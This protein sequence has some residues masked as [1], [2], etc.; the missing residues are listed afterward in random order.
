LLQNTSILGNLDTIRSTRPMRQTA[1]LPFRV[2]FAPNLAPTSM[3]S[4]LRSIALLLLLGLLSIPAQAHRT[5]ESYI[6]LSISDTEVSGRFEVT[7]KD[8]N[9]V[10]KLDAD[11]DG[12]LTDAEFDAVADQAG[13]LMQQTLSFRDGDQVHAVELDGSHPVLHT[14]AGDFA[15]IGFR[16]PTLKKVPEGLHTNYQFLFDGLEPNHRGLLVIADNP[17]TGVV[18]AEAN[19]VG[20]FGPGDYDRYIRFT[21]L[22]WHEIVAEFIKHGAW[23]IWIGYDHILFIITLLLPSVMLLREGRRV[24]VERFGQALWAVVTIITLFTVSHSISLSLAALDIVRL[25][26]RLVESVIAASIAV[27]ALNNIKPIFAARMG[28]L[29]FFF[30]L[31]HGFGFA[32]VLAPLELKQASLIPSLLGFNLGVELGQLAIICAVFPLLYLL[33]RWKNYDLVVLK[34]GS[35]GLIGISSLW[36]LKRAFGW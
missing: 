34:I 25:P 26:S 31:F 20:A 8:L 6:Y 16:I 36:F 28:Y 32:N 33:R 15:Q 19:V 11:G 5:G 27:A 24:P 3:N 7:L 4:R 1:S 30:G 22:A 35:F 10:L 23:H 29:V 13:A 21:P 9:K 12:E 14:Q 17:L 2:R 18:N